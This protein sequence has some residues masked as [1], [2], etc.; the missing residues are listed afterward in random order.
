MGRRASRFITL[1]LAAGALGAL[2]TCD[3]LVA[4]ATT[5]SAAQPASQRPLITSVSP[6]AG[7]AGGGSAVTIHGA[8]FAHVSAVFIGGKKARNVHVISA[9]V[10]KAVS[11]AH[12]P[13]SVAV[14]VQEKAGRSPASPVRYHYLNRPVVTG[15]TPRSGLVTGGQ[16]VTIEG[17]NLSYVRSV[18]FGSLRARPLARSTATRLR[19]RTPVSWAGKAPVTVT[20]WGGTSRRAAGATFSFQNPAPKLSGSLT[21]AAGVDAAAPADVTAVSG[22]PVIGTNSGKAA[23]W[24]VT[25]SGTAPVPSIGQGFLLKPGGKVYPSGLAGAVTAIDDSVSPPAITVSASSTPLDAIAES[26]QAIFTG[27]LGDAAA[28]SRSGTRATIPAGPPSLTSTIDFGSFAASTLNCTDSDGRGVD[29]S[30]SLSLKL[31]DVE[32]HVEVDVGSLF[33]KPFVDVWLSYQQTLAASLSAGYSARCTLPAAWQSTHEKLFPIGDTG[34]TI[35]IAPDATFTISAEGKLSFEQHSYRMLGFI[36]NPDGSIQRLDGKSA[37]PAQ[38]KVSGELKAEAYVGVQVQVGMLNMI[39]VGMSIGGGFAGAATSDWPPQ[40][41]LS[42]YPFLRGT[43]YAYLNDWVKEWKLQAFSVELDLSSLSSCDGQGWHVTWK[44]DNTYLNG[45]A[46]PASAS[47]LAVGRTAKYA[48]AL[49]THDGGAHWSA[50]TVT[51]HNSFSTVAC[52]NASQCIA[53]GDGGKIAVTADGGAT[54]GEASLPGYS[55]SAIGG[56]DAA[57]CLPSG[58]CYVAGSL[59]KYLGSVIYKSTDAGRHWAP[60]QYQPV[61]FSAMTCLTVKDC[62]A[63]GFVPPSNCAICPIAGPAADQVTH[64]G[65]ASSSAGRFPHGEEWLWTVSC[66]S[67]ALCYAGPEFDGTALQTTDF[68]KTW[69]HVPDGGLSP[70]TASCAD[71]T[72]CVLGADQAVAVTKD[73][74]HSWAKTTISKYPWQLAGSDATQIWGLACATPAHCVATE[75]GWDTK[76]DFAAIVVS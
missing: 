19:V 44:T 32:A 20:T 64:D 56:A 50:V 73:A 29:V 13:G 69:K 28:A 1:C 21:P 38:V 22:G 17:R 68:G 39:G 49:R 40:V 51:A 71:A 52:V 75:N 61:T 11:P 6:I 5:G 43:L 35:A 70:N 26:A 12:A 27:P 41:C 18:S 37:D 76:N 46:C 55:G 72:T 10:L 74:G 48:Y 62:V 54:W 57:A 7:P 66:M 53:A 24:T 33:R 14:T 36:T 30:G 23:P 45:I 67:T 47:C 60:A 4:S 9:S 65:W 31:E 3:S 63:V 8:R 16:V 2:V 42:G 15:L 59:V 58:T 34:A 25:L